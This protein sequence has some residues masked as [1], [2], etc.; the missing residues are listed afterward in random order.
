[1][2]VLCHDGITRQCRI[3]GLLRK[4][5]QVFIDIDHI[6]VVSTREAIESDSEDETG[7]SATHETGGTADII[8]LFDEKQSAMLRKTNISRALFANVKAAGGVLEDDSD[9]FDRSE[10]L[11]EETEGKE[12]VTRVL[13]TRTGRA[14]AFTAKLTE[15]GDIDIN[16]I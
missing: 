15:G 1:M 8:G 7:V 10:L 13:G 11:Q 5:G 9:F 2:E 12:D 16:A 6:V 14:A 4:R 3:R